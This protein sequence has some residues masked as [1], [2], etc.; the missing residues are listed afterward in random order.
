M[1]APVT[2]ILPVT[3]IRR[4]RTLPVSGQVMVRVGQKVSA[5]DIIAQAEVPAGHLVL[6]IRRGLR[7]PKISAA[8]KAVIRQ[9]GDRLEKDDVIA[10]TGGMFSRM[11]RAPSPGDVVSVGGGQVVLRVRTTVRE[12]RAG[13]AGTVVEIVK[14][15]GAVIET[16]GA[17]IQG[18]WGNGRSDSGLLL[19]LAKS[20]DEVIERQQIEVSMRGS[21]V[22]AGCCASEDVL[23]AAAELPL[24]GLVLASMSSAL[25]PTAAKMNYP[26]FLVEGFGKIP[27]NEAAY[28][29]L[30]TSDKRDVSVCA[31]MAQGACD[32][33]ELIIPL[34]VVGQPALETDT[35]KP[36]QRV[37]I[38][39][40][41]Y[42]G[43][44]GTLAVLRQGLTALPNGLRAAAAEVHLGDDTRV[45]V[46]LANLEV[47]E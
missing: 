47:I 43:R 12:V 45:T 37:R 2:H 26:I 31:E 29:L 7:I 27:W 19:V 33:P 8:D 25:I 34:P 24:R 21:V 5:T 41:P 30:S 36:G 44:I 15:Q 3:E 16:S 10:E 38:Q 1:L 18:V 20:P 46:P 11:V 32:R 13:F 42:T 6:D 35:F 4:T 9:V 40:A 39:G 23:R 14:D 17:L 28:R 22:M